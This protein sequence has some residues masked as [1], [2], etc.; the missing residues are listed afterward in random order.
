MRSYRLRCVLIY[1]IYIILF[2][3]LYYV[4][5]LFILKNRNCVNLYLLIHNLKQIMRCTFFSILST[6]DQA[7]II[8]LPAVNNNKICF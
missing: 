7:K 5:I 6:N 8:L 1:E 2:D 4:I 3:I